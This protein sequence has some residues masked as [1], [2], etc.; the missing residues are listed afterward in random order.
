MLDVTAAV[1]LSALLGAVFLLLPTAFAAAPPAPAAVPAPNRYDVEIIVFRNTHSDAGT[2]ESWPAN[3]GSPAWERAQPL[4]PET[5][6][7]PYRQLPASSYR[8]DSTWNRLA[9]A[10]GYAPLLHSAWAQ[11]AIDRAS[12]PFIQ[13]GSPPIG[14]DAVYGIAKLSTTG[15]Y[16]HFDLDLLFCGPP[17]KNLIA[18]STAASVATSMPPA[19]ASVQTAMAA[20]GCQP[21]RLREDRKLDAGKLN[22]FDNPMFGALVLITPR[23]R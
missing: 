11:P 13:I 22:Y 3:P 17:A 15:P 1:R 2:L 8:L 12:A 7:L 21:Y 9:R 16:L 19:T 23:A 18:G 5:G 14:N 20:A 10:S 6:N 4:N